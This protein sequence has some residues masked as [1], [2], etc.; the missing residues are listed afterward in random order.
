MKAF[1]LLL[2]ALSVTSCGSESPMRPSPVPPVASTYTVTGTLRATNGG[3]PLSGVM[4]GM[5]SVESLTDG[6]GAFVLTFPVGTATMGYRVSGA[7]VL[8]RQGWFSSASRV[9]DVE[10]FGGAGFDASYY[11]AI[12]HDGADHPGALSPI[13]RWTQAP[14]IYLQTVDD[15]GQSVDLRTLQLVEELYRVAM[16]ALTGG[17]LAPVSIERGTESRVGQAGWLTVRWTHPVD[18]CG[19]A[20]VGLEG[21][22][23]EYAYQQPGCTCQGFGIRPRT[24]KHE[25]GHAMGLWHT[26]RSEDLM[27]GSPTGECDHP[28]TARE[29]QY[30]DFIY[31]RPVGNR[32]P[33]TDPATSVLLQ[34][35]RVH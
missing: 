30:A 11:Q 12:A 14:M 29:Q 35:Q 26:G 24:V 21:G 34:P 19:T 16:P 13:R 32:D 17:R 23:V 6:A 31:R 8:A 27:D 4:V 20:D 5:G 33:D 22:M 10:A 3:L 9:L 15:R 25:L 28:V 7:G 18:Y 2:M 1:G